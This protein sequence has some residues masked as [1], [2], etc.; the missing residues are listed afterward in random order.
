MDGGMERARWKGRRMR[1]VIKY[2]FIATA[3]GKALGPHWEGRREG[4]REGG[5][6][7]DRGGDAEMGVDHTSDLFSHSKWEWEREK[8]GGKG[9]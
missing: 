2:T 8:A 7:G 5:R 9:R 1:C 3:P 4:G 6:E